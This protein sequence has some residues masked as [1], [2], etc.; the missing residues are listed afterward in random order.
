MKAENLDYIGA[1]E[2]LC[3]RAG[4]EMPQDDYAKKRGED[5]VKKARV[6]A[7]NRDAARFY[8]FCAGGRCGSRCGDVHGTRIK[9]K[10]SEN[11]GGFGAFSFGK[12]LDKRRTRR[13][14][15]FIKI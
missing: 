7:A 13:Y 5:D 6:F 14:N 15:D 11:F 3:K 1:V 2:H 8:H 10:R 4:I 9:K 12:V